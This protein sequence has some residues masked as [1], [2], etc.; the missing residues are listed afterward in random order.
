MVLQVGSEDATFQELVISAAYTPGSI[1][2]VL[3]ASLA[4]H[5]MYTTTRFE[6]RNTVAPLSDEK[7]ESG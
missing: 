1:L 5:L 7:T 2:N 6:T 3:Y 4:Y